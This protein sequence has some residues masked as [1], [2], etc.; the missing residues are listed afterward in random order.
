MVSEWYHNSIIVSK[1]YYGI[2]GHLI[3]QYSHALVNYRTKRLT[4]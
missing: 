1:G 4:L 2:N 3:V